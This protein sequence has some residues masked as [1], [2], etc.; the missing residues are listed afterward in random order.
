MLHWKHNSSII[1]QKK[2]TS[3]FR[4]RHREIEWLA[5]RAYYDRREKLLVCMDSLERNGLT[6]ITEIYSDDHVQIFL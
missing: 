6:T 2:T 3:N 1:N 5:K 4:T